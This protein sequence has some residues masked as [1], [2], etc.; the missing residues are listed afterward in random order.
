MKTRPGWRVLR[1]LGSRYSMQFVAHGRKHW[2]RRGEWPY[3]IMASRCT[4]PQ[5]KRHQMRARRQRREVLFRLRME[6]PVVALPTYRPLEWVNA[7]NW[8]KDA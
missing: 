3:D 4:E 5:R 8:G 2:A 1:V 6:Y 7:S